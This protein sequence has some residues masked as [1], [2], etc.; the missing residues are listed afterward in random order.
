VE[1][2]RQSLF[3]EAVELASRPP[4]WGALPSALAAY[5]VLHLLT[6]IAPQTAAG[7]GAPITDIGQLL[8]MLAGVVQYLLPAALLAS[9]AI[10]AKA[11]WMRSRRLATAAAPD[12][13]AR[14]GSTPRRFLG[15]STAAVPE[16]RLGLD[17]LGVGGQGST[18]P[19]PKG[20]TMPSAASLSR[21]RRVPPPGAEDD[22][23]DAI[24]RDL[25]ATIRS[26]ASDGDLPGEGISAPPMR[27]E[28]RGP[29]IRV[30]NVLDGVGIA[31]SLALAWFGIQW[32]AALPAQVDSSPWALLGTGRTSE[33]TTADAAAAGSA[34]RNS[35]QA[36]SAPERPLGQFQ[37]GPA[38]VPNLPDQAAD[39]KQGTSADA[40]DGQQLSLRE[41]EAAF[42]ANYIPPPEC[43][44][45][46]SRAQLVSCGN[47]RMRAL[48]EFVQSG[49]QMS[50]AMLGEPISSPGDSEPA[51]Q[52]QDD[53]G[54]RGAVGRGGPDRRDN[55]TL[56]EGK[57]RRE[58]Q[59]DG[60]P[61]G[62]QRTYDANPGEWQERDW[63]AKPRGWRKPADQPPPSMTWRQ[64]QAWREGRA[65]Q[66]EDYLGQPRDRSG[67]PDW[68]L[69]Y[70]GEAPPEWRRGWRQDDGQ[71]GDWNQDW[72]P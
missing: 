26:R 60:D 43:N 18:K 71:D 20:G 63:H 54:Q 6:Q 7:T 13:V 70:R 12:R 3:E 49:G 40:S 8:V 9:A 66:D 41:L 61:Y 30:R 58:Q 50:A 55:E 44:E 19:D 2:H 23:E 57:R 25:S 39:A 59:L 52:D 28:R 35:K 24:G 29:P 68:R 33:S 36:T 4:W 45:W 65:A 38:Y 14:A 10:S 46:A 11:A 27:A 56:Q 47:H 62:D 72:S 64:E 34:T 17:P 42:N 32:L 53:W 21:Q 15:E 31:L 1:A 67:E 37:F 48:Q 16:F 22:S 5:L 69:R 51:H